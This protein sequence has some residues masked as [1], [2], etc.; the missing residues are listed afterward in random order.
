MEK[1]LLDNSCGIGFLV[2][3]QLPGTCLNQVHHPPLGLRGRVAA[4]RLKLGKMDIVLLGTYCAPVDKKN[5]DEL[6]NRTSSWVEQ[7]RDTVAGFQQLFG[8][9]VAIQIVLAESPTRGKGCGRLR[10]ED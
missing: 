6:A 5:N 7:L 2:S 8:A 9:L 3:N 1:K 10:P 4:L